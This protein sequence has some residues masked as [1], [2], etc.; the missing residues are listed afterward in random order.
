MN[1]Q[2]YSVGQIRVGGLCSFSVIRI[3]ARVQAILESGAAA[4]LSLTLVVAV[5]LKLS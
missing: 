5:R 1:S 4:S 3:K 2:K